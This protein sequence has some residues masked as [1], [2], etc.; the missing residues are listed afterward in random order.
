LNSLKYWEISMGPF[1]CTWPSC[2]CLSGWAIGAMANDTMPGLSWYFPGWFQKNSDYKTLQWRFYC[3][4]RKL[5]FKNKIK[6]R[7]IKY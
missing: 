4:C 2:P 1:K 3:S 7:T 6:D 5:E